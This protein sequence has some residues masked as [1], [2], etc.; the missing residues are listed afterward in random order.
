NYVSARYKLDTATFTSDLSETQD[1]VTRKPTGKR[2][3]QRSNDFG[4]NN[5]RVK[6]RLVI[7][8][9]D[10]KILSRKTQSDKEF[11]QK[12]AAR[13]AAIGGRKPSLHVNNILTDLLTETLVSLI[14]LVR[15]ALKEKLRPITTFKCYICCILEAVMKYKQSSSLVTKDDV[16]NFIQAWLRHANDR[17]QGEKLNCKRR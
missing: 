9:N 6:S 15:K 14:Q 11:R 2:I 10:L 16:V 1:D 8:K 13:F 5:K 7:D 4:S 17:I 3:N 12:L